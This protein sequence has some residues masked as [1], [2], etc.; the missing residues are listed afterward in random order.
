MWFLALSNLVESMAR[1]LCILLKV[2]S[3][4]L[5]GSRYCASLC[6]LVVVGLYSF[7]CPSAGATA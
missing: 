4:T 3:M 5:G 2:A 6:V 1:S 7:S